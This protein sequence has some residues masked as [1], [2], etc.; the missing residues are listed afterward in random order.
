MSNGYVLA[1]GKVGEV[2]N[3]LRSHPFHIYARCNDPRRLAALMLQEDSVMSI[4]IEDEKSVTLLTADP[5]NFY[6]RLNEVIK[7]N[8]IEIEVLTL[9]DEDVQSIYRYLSGRE[10][11]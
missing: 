4:R 2:R 9:A 1:E 5:D 7:K 11:H 8:S 6:L 3:L 10:H